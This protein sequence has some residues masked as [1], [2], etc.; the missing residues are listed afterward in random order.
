[1]KT[2]KEINEKIKKGEVVVL[3]V[4][5]VVKLVEEKGLKGASQAVDVVTTA[6]F[7]PM[8]SSGIYFNIGHTKPRIKLGGGKAALND[9]P[10]HAG[11]AA[12]DLFLGSNS[13]PDD[14]PRNRI[15]PG[16]FS[17]GGGHAIQ[18]LVAGRDLILEATAYGTDCYP[19]KQLKTYINI[20]DLNE[21]MLFNIRNCYQ[22]Y[23]VAINSS[24]KVI[25]TYM[26][27]LQPKLGNANYCSAGCLSPLLCDPFCQTIGIGTRIFLGGGIG[28]VSW[29]GTQHNPDVE[30]TEKG[31]PKYPA[32][33]LALIGDLKKMSEQWLVGTS[34]AG[35]GVTLSVGVGV[36]IPILNEE[37]LSYAAVKDEDILAP[38]VD[39]SKDYPQR[40]SSCLGFV[41][42]AQL[43]SGEIEIE[44]RK[45]STGS[46][47]SLRKAREIA[48]ILKNWIEKG[49]FTL[50]EPVEKIPSVDSNY[51]FK[52]LKERRVE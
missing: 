9:V 32:G 2:I 13:L 15:Y 38:I 12:V 31:I 19:R 44:G 11:L 46:L 40:E 22:N 33:T 14:D 27:I 49:Q 50:T 23:N 45:I 51:K 37:I 24:E 48:N 20:N 35:Y 5:E 30:R 36:P 26:G 7:G 41:N 17:Y 10:C 47:S 4:E 52:P 18:D 39:Y 42:Y 43:K 3:T 29:W 21:A 28:Y 25:Y 1:M 6:T 16:E 8:C 34:M